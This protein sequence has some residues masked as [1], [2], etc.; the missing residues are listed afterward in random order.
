MKILYDQV[1][2][3]CS[4]SITL[5]YSTSFSLGI[6]ML[7]RQFHQPIYAIYGFVRLADEIVDTFH[8]FN[9]EK[10]LDKFEQDT[11]EAIQEGISLNPV[12]HSFQHTVNKYQI[13][14]DLIAC[15]L[16]SM[17]MDLSRL[18]HNATSYKEYI[19]GSAEVVGLMC[20]AVFCRGNQSQ[21]QHLKPYAMRLGAAFQKINFL[22]DL[23]ADFQQL[24]RSYFPNI[25]LTQ[26]DE[27][28]K[29]AI[30]QEIAEDFQAGLEGI[31]MLP[32]GAKLG[33]YVAYVYYLKLFKQISQTSPHVIM[34]QRVRVKDRKKLQLLIGSYVRYNLR[35]I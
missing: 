5:K 19:L 6:W 33:V 11:W 20:L 31:K 32:R 10:L 2:Q 16:K 22:R 21:Y 17:R 12:L 8:D 35:M 1:S 28:S 15:F 14:H 30:E 23:N 4:K 3:R 25:N 13:D 27:S 34:K 7:H 24:G 18:E 26:F 9:K 29:R